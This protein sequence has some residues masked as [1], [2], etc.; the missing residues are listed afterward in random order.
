MS[1]LSDAKT[2]GGIGS[3]LLFVPA[4][5]IVGY[6][7]VL[8]ATKFI[9]DELQ[10]KSIFDNMLIA[11]ITGIIG[12]AAGAFLVFTGALFGVF[13]VGLSALFGIIAALVIGWIFLIISA[14]Y[15]RRAYNTVASKLNINY[16]RTTATLW[17][18]GAVL[19]I[20]LVGFIILFI[21]FIFQIIA[22]FSIQETTQ[23]TTQVATPVQSTKFC[24]NCGAQIQLSATFCPKCG[25]KQ[26]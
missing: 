24:P 19:T 15:V 17:F 14:L 18:W 10:D 16:F 2:I 3:I 4:V 5:S 26:P 13:T 6:I 12:F 20:I 11:A 1:K 22:F 21:A 25:A 7:L 8:I 23:A 9:S